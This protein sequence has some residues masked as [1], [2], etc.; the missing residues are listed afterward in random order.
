MGRRAACDPGGRARAQRYAIGAYDAHA[1]PDTQ[2][3]LYWVPGEGHGHPPGGLAVTRYK[4]RCR[5]DTET[6]V[7][8]ALPWLTVSGSHSRKKDGWQELDDTNAD[9]STIPQEY[10]WTVVLFAPDLCLYCISI[11]LC[12]VLVFSTLGY[13]CSPFSRS[14]HCRLLSHRPHTSAYTCS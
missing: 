12:I 8:T 11:W 2:L 9:C 3:Q 5:A 1:E 7:C 4:G 6:R 10:M 14:P 13:S